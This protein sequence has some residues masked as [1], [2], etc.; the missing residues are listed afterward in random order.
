MN[1]EERR[2]HGGARVDIEIDVDLSSYGPYALSKLENVSIGGAF[3]KSDTL[4]PVGT[5]L[6]LKFK[7][8]GDKTPIEAE[9]EV[10]WTYKQR[11]ASLMNNSGLGV[12]FTQIMQSDRDRIRT[13]I[14]AM[15]GSSESS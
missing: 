8:P 4:H 14:K 6:K 10:M 7:L 13:F 12:K 9:G 5:K 3:V 15:T 2:S 1:N 11:G